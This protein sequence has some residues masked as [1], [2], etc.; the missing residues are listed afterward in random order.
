MTYEAWIR[1]PVTIVKNLCPSGKR[2]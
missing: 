2:A 1:I